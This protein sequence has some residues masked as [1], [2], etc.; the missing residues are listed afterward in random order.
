MATT[1]NLVLYVAA[2]DDVTAASDDFVLLQDADAADELRILGAVVIERDE[3]GEVDVTE[4]HTGLVG[5]GAGAGGVVGL[6]V[7]LFAP[8]LLLST[9][10]GAAIGAGIG[11]LMKHHEES[12]LEIALH[13]YLPPG[14]SA[15]VAI[16]EDRHLDRID[17]AL[18]KS[19][20]KVS[21]AIDSGDYEKIRR[22]LENAGYRIGTAAES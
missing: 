15:V 7:G 10:A 4:H 13:D 21:K 14:S 17:S 12:Q 22:E 19:V 1:Q 3:D 16:A 20:K 6:V 2:Y 18:S 8:P 5:G 9:A 11:A